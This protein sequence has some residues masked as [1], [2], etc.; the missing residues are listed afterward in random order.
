MET[1]TF[2]LY[3]SFKATCIFC[4]VTKVYISSAN[5][6]IATEKERSR[7]YLN[8]EKSGNMMIKWKHLF[9]FPQLYSTTRGVL[10]Q[11]LNMSD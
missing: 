11:K 10:G 8:F 6:S 4:L 5:K 3:F 2:A 1:D 9:N 7:F